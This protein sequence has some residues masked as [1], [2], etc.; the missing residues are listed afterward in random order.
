MS[1]ATPSDAGLK[2]FDIANA[3]A[4][5]WT[6][7]AARATRRTVERRGLEAALPAPPPPPLPAG[8]VRGVR[9]VLRRGHYTCVVRSIVM[10]AWLA[11]HGE[12]L[13]LIV[14]VRAPGREF[15]AHA[16]L[17]GEPPHAEGPFHELLRRPASPP[18]LNDAELS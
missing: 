5:L 7:R 6:Q 13:D 16:W 3:R 18:A 17:E 9:A 12:E 1:S 8:A 10:Q 2:R 15:A 11:A 14:G 4:A